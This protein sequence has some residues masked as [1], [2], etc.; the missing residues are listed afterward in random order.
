MRTPI[1]WGLVLWISILAVSSPQLRAQSAPD[2]HH[3]QKIRAR[4]VDALNH[5]R[6]V[7]VVT[8]DH[9]SLQGVV[10]EADPD[11][12]VL[13]FEGRTTTLTYAEVERISWPHHVSRPVV[14][15]VTGVAVGV[16]LYF[17]LHALLEKNG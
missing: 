8:A 16:A 6:S 5:H 9:R 4:A 12:F 14:A 10:S 7:A 17:I 1:C 2:A 11:K 15:G 3:E 13:A